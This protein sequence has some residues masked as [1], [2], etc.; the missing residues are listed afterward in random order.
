MG[1]ERRLLEVKFPKYFYKWELEPVWER[2][3]KYEHVNV[4]DKVRVLPPSKDPHDF[5]PEY[6]CKQCKLRM[7][8]GIVTDV[9][10]SREYNDLTYGEDVEVKLDNDVQEV[11]DWCEWDTGSSRPDGCIAHWTELEHLVYKRVSHKVYFKDVS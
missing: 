2:Y 8:T 9:P 5:H 7:Y 10:T 3:Q 6:I 11:S 1:L 4:R